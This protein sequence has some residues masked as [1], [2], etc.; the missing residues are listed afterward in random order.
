MKTYLSIAL[1]LSTF[2]A[3]SAEAG[4]PVYRLD[5]AKSQVSWKGKFMGA[6][7]AASGKFKS[8]SFVIKNKTI[9]SATV[10]ADMNSLQSDSGMD[11]QFKGPLMLNVAKYPT[12]EFKLKTFTE[13]KSFAPGGPNAR[14]TGTVVLRGQAHGVTAEFVM[15]PDKNGFHATGSFETSYGKMLAGTVTYELWTKK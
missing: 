13:L 11:A 1:V 3:H 10:I 7:V 5:L 2:F 12:A 15:V 9:Q 6:A 14:V 8:G 4:S